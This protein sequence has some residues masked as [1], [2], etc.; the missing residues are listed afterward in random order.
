MAGREQMG[1]TTV[2][3]DRGSLRSRKQSSEVQIIQTVIVA[4]MRPC[5]I[6]D[7]VRNCVVPIANSSKAALRPNQKDAP[8][9]SFVPAPLMDLRHALFSQ[10]E[11]SFSRPFLSVSFK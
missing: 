6:F 2:W 1:G 11:N 3:R 9:S 4:V 7:L 5:C 8:S 10:D